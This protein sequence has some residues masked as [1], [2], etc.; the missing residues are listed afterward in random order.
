MIIGMDILSAVGAIISCNPP[1][2]SVAAVPAKVMYTSEVQLGLG[3]SP[4]FEGRSFR[5]WED[6]DRPRL[7]EAAFVGSVV[8]GDRIDTWAGREVIPP[9]CA[10]MSPVWECSDIAPE[11]FEGAILK[12]VELIVVDDDKITAVALLREFKDIF[13]ENVNTLRA[14]KGPNFE[15]NTFH[16]RPV[17]R[18][19]GSNFSTEQLSFLDRE[20]PRLLALG[21][22]RASSS[23]YNSPPVIVPKPIS[24]DG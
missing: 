17:G 1:S 20:V 8:D 7:V 6:D 9:E 14:M 13:R 11:K 24:A 10:E 15:I 23:L 4:S 22:L 19:G 21:V 12:T 3:S 18:R 2:L 5:S 16:E